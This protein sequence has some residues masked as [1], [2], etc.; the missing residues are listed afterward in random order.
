MEAQESTLNKNIFFLFL[1]SLLVTI[2]GGTLTGIAVA[3]VSSL[4][5]II[6]LFPIGMGLVGG[7]I[8]RLG[9]RLAKTK[10]ISQAILLSILVAISI[11]GTYH[12]TKYIIFRAQAAVELLPKLT[13]VSRENKAEVASVLIDRALVKGTGHSGFVGYML[14]KAQVG[15]SLEHFYNNDGIN[16]GIGIWTYFLDGAEYCQAGGASACM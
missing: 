14:L 16:L 8:V 10:K 2:I 12:Y 7:G 6:F 5:Y 4:F 15:V 1:I 9:I 3:V 13:K 11:Y